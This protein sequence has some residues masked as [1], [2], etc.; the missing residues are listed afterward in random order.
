MQGVDAHI[1][2]CTG[3]TILICDRTAEFFADGLVNCRVLVG[4]CSSSTFVRNCD[5]CTFWVATKQF[6]TRDCTNCTFYLHSHTEPIIETSSDIS[7]APFA[8]E[9]PGLAAQ[10]REAKFDLERNF[11]S[12][13]Y[14]FTGRAD[15]A[16][17]R[18]Q[19][20]EECEALVVSFADRPGEKPEAV[21]PVL[22][23]ELL[24]APPPK[25]EE[26]SGHAVASIPQTR[27]DPPRAPPASWRGPRRRRV[28]D[29]EGGVKDGE[30]EEDVGSLLSAAAAAVRAVEDDDDDII[31]VASSSGAT[32]QRAV[33]K[34]SA[35]PQVSPS[36]QAAS[37][38]SAGIAAS[39]GARPLGSVGGAAR[40]LMMRQGRGLVDSDDSDDDRKAA[41]KLA[42]SGA[43]ALPSS[44]GSSVQRGRPM[45]GLSASAL[46]EGAL[47]AA[48][49]RHRAQ[50]L[51][52]AGILNEDDDDESSEE[53]AVAAPRPKAKAAA[54]SIA[55]SSVA[56][57]AAATLAG[58][59]AAVSRGG[60]VTRGRS[61]GN[62][63]STSESD[64]QEAAAAAA[65]WA[66]KSQPV[67]PQR[68]PS[69]DSDD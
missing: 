32:P 52:R 14:D 27:P 16:N 55:A 67:R 60:R 63:D 53:E 47:G 26:G 35:A 56:A 38:S 36:A 39:S 6:R 65:R 41:R 21:A 66:A 3:C 33:A 51:Q 54:T 34:P 23:Q 31:S 13:I 22:S 2:D 61:P 68:P 19:P 59:T 45:T 7:L 1:E 11:W 43:F 62:D 40:G 58:P 42:G 44:L 4:P 12:A 8:A 30:V 5:G 69:D 9:Y 17:W 64:E 10:F 18:F 15:R 20:L 29:A 46:A 25:S 57:I 49:A 48:A 37:S 24:A 50:L 28:T